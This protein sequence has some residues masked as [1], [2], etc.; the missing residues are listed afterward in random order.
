MRAPRRR[1]AWSEQPAKWTAEIPAY[2]PAS[3]GHRRPTLEKV[4]GV[5]AKTG[6]AVSEQQPTPVQPTTGTATVKRGMAEMLKGGVVMDVVT[7]D[8]AELA[9]RAGAGAVLA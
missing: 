2:W 3:S 9:W 1:M 8:H 6:P 4:T 5:F 7:D